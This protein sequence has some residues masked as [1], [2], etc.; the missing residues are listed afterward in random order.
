MPCIN[1]LNNCWGA[2]N[3]KSRLLTFDPIKDVPYL[4][5]GD[6]SSKKVRDIT[7]RIYHFIFGRKNCTTASACVLSAMIVNHMID[8][9]GFIIS[10]ENAMMAFYY[11]ILKS[12]VFVN[13]FS[14]LLVRLFPS[15]S[16]TTF[17]FII[18]YLLNFLPNVKVL[19]FNFSFASRISFSC[20]IVARMFKTL[21]FSML[22]VITL[23]WS[24]ITFDAEIYSFV[25]VSLS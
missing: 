6:G 4:W 19:V 15:L 18:L 24:S 13:V 14:E 7:S 5:P 1:L 8:M 16:H 20:S 9:N 17:R 2:P 23:C 10:C 12:V 25:I 21:F 22:S 3:L 11:Q